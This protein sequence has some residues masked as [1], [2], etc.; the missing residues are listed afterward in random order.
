MT[1]RDE[2]ELAPG[3]HG[4]QAQIAFYASTPA[5]RPV[6]E[7]HGWGDLQTE[8]HPLSKRGEWVEMAE[9]ID[10]DILDAS[11]SSRRSTRSPP[12]W[13]SGSAG[14]STA[15]ASTPRT[16]SITDGSGRCSAGS[17]PSSEPG[18]RPA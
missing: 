11:P 8:L 3:V 6:L 10:D 16:G 5:Y 9:L 4:S 15:S 13:S 1:G 12:E 7:L 17:E 14:W 2:A 18:P